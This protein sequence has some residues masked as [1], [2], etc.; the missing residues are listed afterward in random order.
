MGL[1]KYAIMEERVRRGEAPLDD[2]LYELHASVCQALANPTR[3]KA[4]NALRAGEMSVAELAGEV[5]T[6]LS[7]LS[8]HL[9][10]LK[11]KRIVLARR[12]GVTVH[13]RLAN[14][15][16]LRAFDLMREVLFEQLAEGQRLYAAYAPDA[17]RG[18]GGEG[19]EPGRAAEKAL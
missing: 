8:R 1:V 17:R 15:K 3:L 12:Q 10:I 19:G 5:G 7:N 13:Y 18:V 2:H 16:I 4:L 11:T 14:P 6:S 9:A